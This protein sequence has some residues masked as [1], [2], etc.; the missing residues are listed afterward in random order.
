[1]AGK[2]E[3]EVLNDFTM[4]GVRRSRRARPRDTIAT[5]RV[6]NDT[7][8]DVEAAPKRIIQPGARSSPA[9]GEIGIQQVRKAVPSR[10]IGFPLHRYAAL[11]VAHGAYYPLFEEI[12]SLARVMIDVGTTGMGPGCPWHGRG[13][14]PRP[15]VGD[16]SAPATS[17]I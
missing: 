17:R 16:R 11:R 14:P 6:T 8:R 15:S 13:Y 2:T 12:A 4:A 1:V 5:P 3:D 9:K 7:S 10:L